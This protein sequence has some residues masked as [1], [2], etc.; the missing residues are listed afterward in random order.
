MPRHKRRGKGTPTGKF[1]QLSHWFMDTPAWRTVAPG[2]RA[3]YVELR[4]R[5]N[6]V[7]NGRITL[8]HREAAEALSVHRN[9]VGRWFDELEARGF[10]TAQRGHCLGPAG[11]GE[12]TLWALDE[13]PLEG[14]PPAKRFA[15]WA[16][17][18]KQKPRTKS[19]TPRHKNQDTP[20]QKPGTSEAKKGATVL[21][22]VTA[23]A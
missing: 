10:I 12:T 1:V 13:E 11:I 4:R 17:T 2:P 9:T 21:K 6:G 15:R 14:Q 23:R 8:S 16:R 18:E 19:V 3:L 7:N 5:F 20:A 22:I